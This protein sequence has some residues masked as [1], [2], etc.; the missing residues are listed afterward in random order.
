M[1]NI[2]SS[3]LLS[4]Y[5]ISTIHGTS[6]LWD[7]DDGGDYP[8]DYGY[9]RHAD[10]LF[11]TWHRPYLCMYEQA[12]LDQ[13][14]KIVQTF[15]AGT[16]KNQHLAAL[17]SWR[18]P[19]WDWAMDASMPDILYASK[20]VVVTMMQNKALKN[21]SINNPLYSYTVDRYDYNTMVAGDPQKGTRTME[22]VRNPIAQNKI[23][24]SR[25]SVTNNNMIQAQSG[26]R[27][28]TYDALTLSPDYKSF[29]N[30]QDGFDSIESIH[31]AVHVTVGGPNG[32]MAYIGYAAFDPIF[33]LH[34]CNIDR[35]CAMWQALYP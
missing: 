20:K 18:M 11:P 31:G 29:S 28:D 25:P 1:Q 7:D 5:R 9:C 21:V 17:Q 10:P 4:H 34:H 35:L 23:W 26:L 15:P 16:V 32:H 24:V 30:M 13:A 19:Y 14:T 3:Q 22:T 8:S 12:I 33:Y 2:S 27:R 6:Y